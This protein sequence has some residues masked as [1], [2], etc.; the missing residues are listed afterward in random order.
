MLNIVPERVRGVMGIVL[1]ISDLLV[2]LA[3]G[4]GGRLT[5]RLSTH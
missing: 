1:S 4:P 5:G 2:C 3:G